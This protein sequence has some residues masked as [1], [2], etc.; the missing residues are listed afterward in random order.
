MAR[1]KYWGDEYDERASRGEMNVKDKYHRLAR[2]HLADL[3]GLTA[4][5]KVKQVLFSQ[6]VHNLWG[7]PKSTGLK[8]LWVMCDETWFHA[9]VPR[10]NAKACE[11]LGLHKSTYSAHHKSH[12]SKVMMH[13]TMGYLFAD[14]PELRGQGYLIGCN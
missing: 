12:I 9:L 5:N 2:Q 8:I 11:E 13:C 4:E 10:T 7:L 3:R 1:Q 14:D 6:H